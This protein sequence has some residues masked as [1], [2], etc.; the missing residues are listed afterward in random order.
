MK[1]TNQKDK[2]DWVEVIAIIGIATS[3]VVVAYGLAMM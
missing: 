2:V 3:L 1:N